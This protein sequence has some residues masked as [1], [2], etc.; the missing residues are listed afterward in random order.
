MNNL[1]CWKLQLVDK[2]KQTQINDDSGVV[3]VLTAGSP[4]EATIYSDLKKTAASNPLTFTDGAVTFWTLASVTSVDL[5]IL[6]ANGEAL[7]IEG[8]TSGEIKV[9]V[10]TQKR[11][12]VLIIPFAASDNTVTDT[13]FD[14]PADMLCE[15]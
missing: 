14:L 1:T 8:Q 12:Q 11:E 15:D 3:N 13:G 5:S 9:E 10:D 2:R 6:T 4:V 7:F